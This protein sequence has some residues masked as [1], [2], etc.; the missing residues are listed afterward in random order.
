MHKPNVLVHICKSLHGAKCFIF[1]MH[2][3]LRSVF[4]PNIAFFSSGVPFVHFVLLG[5]FMLVQCSGDRYDF[6]I[7]NDVRFVFTP[8]CLNEGS[9]LVCCCLC[10]VVSTAS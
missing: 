1:I 10:I 7:T 4:V 3:C 6:R 5:V 2:D 8:S 9:C